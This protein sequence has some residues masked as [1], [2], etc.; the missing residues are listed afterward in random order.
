MMWKYVVGTRCI[1]FLQR[2]Y[3]QGD[4]DVNIELGLELHNAT[5][6]CPLSHL[7]RQTSTLCHNP[8]WPIHH[9]ESLPFGARGRRR[10]IYCRREVN[11]STFHTHE[12]KTYRNINSKAQQCWR[13]GSWDGTETLTHHFYPEK[14]GL[15]HQ[16]VLE[17]NWPW[18]YFS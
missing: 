17:P 6:N 15:C 5:C 18:P 7:A 8:S 3:D 13:S 2:F 12:M 9:T 10:R 1:L 16:L 14:S 4:K 11:L